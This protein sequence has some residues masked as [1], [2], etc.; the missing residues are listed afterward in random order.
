[1][2]SDLSRVG[3]AARERDARPRAANSPNVIVAGLLLTGAVVLAQ[4]AGQ[5]IDFRFFDL[6]LRALDSNHHASVFGAASL[7]AQAGAA[8]AIAVRIARSPRR[9]HWLIVAGL[10]AVLLVVRTFV[11]PPPAVLLL[12]LAV[13]FFAVSSL[14]WEDPAAIRLTVWGSLSLLLCS[15]ALHVVGP[16]ADGTRSSLPEDTWTFQLTGM[17]KHGA[18]LAGWMLL[19]TCMAAAHRSSCGLPRPRSGD[20]DGCL[21]W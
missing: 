8:S 9:L 13:V 10:L 2:D 3:V 6:K 12:P 14:T 18:E 7:L 4:A 20:G 11:R 1:M 5:W 15:F 17:L 19:A 16:Q 21:P